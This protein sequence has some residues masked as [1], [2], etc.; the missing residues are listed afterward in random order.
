MPT[1]KQIILREKIKIFRKM[2]EVYERPLLS[3][4]AFSMLLSRFENL[5]PVQLEKACGRAMDTCRFC[6]TPADI[7]EAH[8]K[9]HQE[10]LESD[11][12]LCDLQ[13]RVYAYMESKFGYQHPG[14]FCQNEL[15]DA[16]D[17]VGLERNAVG[18]NEMS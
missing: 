7:L 4:D 18:R 8:Q 11:Q 3:D 14:V 12:W 9:L 10:W 1:L 5:N 2:Y 13:P 17:H 15:E 16:L 6:P